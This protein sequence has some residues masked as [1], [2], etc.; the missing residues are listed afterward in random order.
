MVP[1]SAQESRWVET[2]RPRRASETQPQLLTTLK[3]STHVH[4]A[5]YRVVRSVVKWKHT[6]SIVKIAANALLSRDVTN[7][8]TS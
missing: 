1:Q 8:L 7:S 4:H 6:V 5:T 2:D 3:N